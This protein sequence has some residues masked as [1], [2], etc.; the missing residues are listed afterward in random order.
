MPIRQGGRRRAG[1]KLYRFQIRINT[2]TMIQGQMS[3]LF[4]LFHCVEHIRSHTVKSS[5]YPVK[6]DRETQYVT[7]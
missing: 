1:Y 3:Y 7:F 2:D 5:V 4:H 6:H